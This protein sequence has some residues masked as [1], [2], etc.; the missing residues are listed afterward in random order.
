MN[1]NL[2]KICNVLI[3]F[4]Y[5]YQQIYFKRKKKDLF[6]IKLTTFFNIYNIYMPTLNT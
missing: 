5:S 6:T 2:S 3:Y 4:N 1:L